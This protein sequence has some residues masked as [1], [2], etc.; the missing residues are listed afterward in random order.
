MIGGENREV[1]LITEG[2]GVVQMEMVQIFKNV[3]E[4]GLVKKVH[5]KKISALLKY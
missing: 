1:K 2:S 4:I 3:I 5:I